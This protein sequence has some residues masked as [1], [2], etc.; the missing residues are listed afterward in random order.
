MFLFITGL[1]FSCGSP[2][3]KTEVGEDDAAPKEEIKPESAEKLKKV[4]DLNVE[5]E[6]VDGELD[7]LIN[8]LN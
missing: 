3:N 8:Y 4:Q 5:I 6:E 1:L 7:S 2:E